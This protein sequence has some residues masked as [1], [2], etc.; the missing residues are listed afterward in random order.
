MLTAIGAFWQWQAK[1]EK[2]S[3]AAHQFHILRDDIQLLELD[4]V[5]QDDREKRKEVK[6]KAVKMM[7]QIKRDVG[8]VPAWVERRVR[9]MA[10]E[11]AAHMVDLYVN[12]QHY[13]SGGCWRSCIT[14]CPIWR[15]CCFCGSK[16]PVHPIQEA[17]IR[18]VPSEV[19]HK[20]ILSLRKG[21][22]DKRIDTSLGHN[23]GSHHE[24][25]PGEENKGET[26]HKDRS[27]DKSFPSI[28]SEQYDHTDTKQIG[29]SG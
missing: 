6:A 13:T 19:L 9:K 14:W 7:S 3:Q 28:T 22:H 4:Y 26:L 18:S 5:S 16:K 12:E 25:K 2:H 15:H 23:N 10:Y 21:E 29:P 27:M 17:S 24:Q 8:P 11:D 20:S 1:A